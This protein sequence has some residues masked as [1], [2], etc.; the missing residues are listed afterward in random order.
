MAL[1]KGI[2]IVNE[3]T[4]NNNG[5]GSRGSTPGDYVTRYMSRDKATETL[6]PVKLTEQEDYIER[7]M[8]REEAVEYL[9]DRDEVKPSFREIQKKGGI[10]FGYGSV[11]LSDEKLKFVSKDIQAQFD[12]GKTVL[13][14]VLSFDE[15]YLRKNKIIPENFV[16]KNRGDFRGNID[17]MKLRMG[18]MHGLDVLAKDYDD[19]QYVGVIQ[20]DTMHVHCHLAMVDRGKGNITQDGTQKGKLSSAQKAKLR[21]H[22]DLFLDESKSIQHMSS[23]VAMDKRNTI[24]FVKQVLHKTMEQ[25]GVAQFLLACL[26]KD[27]RLW[28]ASTNSKSMRKANELTRTYV[29]ELFEQ[30]DSGYDKVKKSI[31]KYAETRRDKEDLS[32]D[33]CH[34]LIKNGVKRVEDE[35]MNAVYGMLRGIQKRDK[36]VHTPMLDLMAMSVQNISKDA[37]EFGEFTYKLRSYSTRLDYH[38]KGREKAHKIVQSYEKAKEQGN[39]SPDSLPV[40]EFF[41]FEEEYNEMLMCKYQHFL[42]FL[43]P[44]DKYKD[45]LRDL[46]DYKQCVKDVEAMYNDSSIRRMTENNA[47]TYAERVYNQRGGRYM[48]SMPSVIETRI[49]HMKSKL[50][51]KD[52]D[53]AFKIAIDGLSID[54][55]APDPKLE[56]HIK[57]DFEDVKALDIHHMGYDLSLDMKVSNKNAK[58]FIEMTK[59]R[60]NLAEAARRYLIA[61]GQRSELENIDMRDIRLMKSVAKE[62]EK[63]HVIKSKR[64]DTKKVT[65]VQTINLG[66]RY[67]MNIPVKQS[68]V[69]IRMDEDEDITSGSRMFK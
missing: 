3:Y 20:V 30:P 12:K 27:K 59:R 68:L 48:V 42:R 46:L 17:Q 26:P 45:E 33:E 14:T 58:R 51:K 61:S 60:A 69:E 43:P 36:K 23:N 62:V 35:C 38:K 67:D 25:N 39:V 29:R 2:V 34:K 8:A 32:D 6:T 56:R 37:D 64:I 24:I 49:T 13:K 7:Y 22:I 50:K 5:K 31:Q 54:L 65:P 52:A 21:R 47:E 28:R 9:D 15:E 40:Y 11:S 10:A 1:A 63:K 4:I 55:D 18:I 19:L 41:K 53:F 16:C 66:S 57:Y 44:S